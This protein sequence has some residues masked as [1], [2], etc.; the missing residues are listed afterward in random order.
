M[1]Q[2]ER[3]RGRERTKH[4]SEGNGLMPASTASKQQESVEY[5]ELIVGTTAVCLL[6]VHHLN[7]DLNKGGVNAT[8]C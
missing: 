4:A 5:D 1:R 8:R 7:L 3:E 2:G 6:V